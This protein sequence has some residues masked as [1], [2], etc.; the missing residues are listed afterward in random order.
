MVTSDFWTELESIA[1]DCVFASGLAVRGVGTVHPLIRVVK[2]VSGGRLTSYVVADRREELDGQRYFGIRTQ[3]CRELDFARYDRG[4]A[5]SAPEIKVDSLALKPAFVALLTDRLE[6]TSVRCVPRSALCG[7]DGTRYYL[8][9][10]PDLSAHFR[11]YEA[12]PE[13]WKPLEHLALDVIAHLER[14]LSG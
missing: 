11:W 12:A 13:E 8:N 1:K 7:S 2:D 4:S 9:V 14:E 6:Q 5:M 3:W 10:G